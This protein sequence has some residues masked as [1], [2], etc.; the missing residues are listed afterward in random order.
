MLGHR[1][2]SNNDFHTKSDMKCIKNNLRS[3]AIPSIVQ[4]VHGISVSSYFAENLI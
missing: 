3:L 4:I 2:E 1:R